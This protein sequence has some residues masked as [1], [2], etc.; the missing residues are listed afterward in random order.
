MSLIE[1]AALGVLTREADRGSRFEEGGVGEEFCHAVVKG[2]LAGT[3][4]DALLE[5][6]RYFGVDVEALGC[7][8][9]RGGEGG[10]FGEIEAGARVIVVVERAAVVRLPVVTNIEE[11]GLAVRRGGCL[12]LFE[13]ATLRVRDLFGGVDADLFGIDLEEGRVVLDLGITKGLGDGRVVDFGVAVATIADEVD[14]DV[15]VKGLAIF[16][17]EGC[18]AD[19]GC[20]I[21]G[22]DVEDG[23]GKAL[24]EVG[25]EPRGVGLAGEGGKAEEVV[26]DDLDG[27]ADVVAVEGSEVE[28]LGPDT[29]AGEGGVAVDDH[30]HD[31]AAGFEEVGFGAIL[32]EALLVGAS[33][34]HDDGVGGLEVAGVGGQMEVY[35]FAGSGDEVAGGAGVVFDVASSEGGAG[36][37]VF[38]LGKDVAGG[39]VDGVDHNVEAAAVAH[40]EDRA[41]DAELGCGGEELV[42]ERDQDGEALE[43]EALGAEVALLDDL[44]EEVGAEE[45]GE[46]AV[47]GNDGRGRVSDGSFEALLDPGALF[48]GGDVHELGA[49]GGSVDAAS[50][51]D[52]GGVFVG[53]RLGDGEGR[54]GEELA[55]RVEGGLEVAPA[56]E[57][58][59]GRF[60]GGFPGCFA[61]DFLCAR[62][63]ARIG[64]HG[65]G[66]GR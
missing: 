22:V 38:E 63:H 13:E 44:L 16:G 51:L 23:D 55:E 33:A 45:A 19:H 39:S 49:D 50:F 3:H 29:L 66:F 26:D 56:A 52:V 28:G 6:L 61:G 54:R 27:S 5:E 48:S 1:G 53:R 42:K 64:C 12:L 30:G 18:D 20:G 14:D 37:N 47:V 7:C 11:A 57:E 25:R 62:R 32:G 34:A 40:G 15:G 46:D 8:R 60:P 2:L 10:N 35:G 36:V 59:E 21:F 9:E 43:G 24:G 31:L 17:C 41:V 65:W 58:V 4:F